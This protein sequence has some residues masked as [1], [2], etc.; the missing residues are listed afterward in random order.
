MKK[1]VTII[2]CFVMVLVGWFANDILLDREV[3]A[4]NTL[5]YKVVP[6]D[7]MDIRSDTERSK[8]LEKILN[9]NAKAG[10]KLHSL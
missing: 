6:P 8:A 4:E 3:S 9:D 2:L 10:W 1:G 7:F 5:K